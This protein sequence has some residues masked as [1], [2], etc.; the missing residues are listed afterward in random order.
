MIQQIESNDEGFT[1]IWSNA[2]KLECGIIFSNPK[3]E[4]DPFFNKLSSVTCIS[5][6]MVDASIIQFKKNHSNPYVYSLNY[7]EFENMLKRKGFVYHDTQHVLKNRRLPSKKPTVTKISPDKISLWTGI[8]CASYDCPKWT[9]TVNAILKNSISS[10]EY[11]VDESNSSCM[12]L[13]EKNSILGLYCLG[14]IPDKRKHGFAASLI[15]FALHEVKSRN[16]G[17]LILESYARDNLTQF[18][19]K[20]GFEQVYNKIIYTI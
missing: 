8:F 7:P 1:G 9:K 19:S 18:Y 15:D 11:Y 13:Y 5:E 10:V 12:A 16:L 3:L 4:D 14:T 20:L 6:K 17:F 2:T